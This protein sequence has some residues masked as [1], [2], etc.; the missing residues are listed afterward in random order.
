MI[1]SKYNLESL[2]K[3]LK[4]NKQMALFVGAGVNMSSTVNL[5][6]GALMNHLF[7]QALGFL[8]I[9]KNIPP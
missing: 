9:E 6:W 4:N 1:V 5:S 7:N 8:A 2:E 3:D